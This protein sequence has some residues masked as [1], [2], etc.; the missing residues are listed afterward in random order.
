MVS[1]VNTHDSPSILLADY[2]TMNARD[3][4]NISDISN[5]P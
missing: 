1:V 3:S 4:D 2:Y 5:C